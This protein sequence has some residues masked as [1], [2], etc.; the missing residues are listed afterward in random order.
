MVVK[1]GHT[2]IHCNLSILNKPRGPFSE[3]LVHK[4]FIFSVLSS[5]QPSINYVHFDLHKNLHDGVDNG[6]QLDVKKL[7]INQIQEQAVSFPP[8]VLSKFFV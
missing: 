7:N 1:G 8:F 6:A 2:H 5:W 4:L 3:I